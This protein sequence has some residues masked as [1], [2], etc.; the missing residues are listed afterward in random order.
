VDAEFLAAAGTPALIDLPASKPAPVVTPRLSIP[1]LNID[2]RLGRILLSIVLAILLW[3]Y[4]ARSENPPAFTQFTDMAIEVRGLTSSLKVTNPVP[5]VVAR[6]RA[7]QDLLGTLTKPSIEPYL[8]LAG[9]QEGV[10][11]VPV[12]AEISSRR[13]SE[14]SVDFT[15]RTVQVQLEV[16]IS[17]TLPVEV[18]TVGTPAIG[19]GLQPAQV[20]PAEVT[21]QGSTDAVG[22]VQAV[23][24]Q[25]NVDGRAGTQQGSMTPMAVDGEGREVTGVTF[26]PEAVDVVVPIKLLLN[27]RT[28]PVSVPLEGQPAPGYRVAS[29]TME[30][31]NVTVCCSPNDLEDLEFLNTEPVPITGTTSTIVTSTRL[32]L[33]SNIELYPGQPNEIKV[34]VKVE[35]L[36]TTWQ[37]AV[38]P[39]VEGVADNLSAVVSPNQL[40]LTLAGTFAQLQSLSPSDIRAIVNVQ[41]RAAGTYSLRPQIV[42]PQGIK[43]DRL[44]PDEVT[45]TL[46]APTPVPTPTATPLPPSSTPTPQPPTPAVSTPEAT[47]APGE[48]TPAPVTSPSDGEGSTP[49]PSPQLQPTPSP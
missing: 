43:L 24:V 30:P 39:T 20:S 23:I 45:V 15:P 9:L 14:V 25:V 46:I 48:G 34:T 16:Q 28:V 44:A 32:V 8:D 5:T 17:K 41:G 11:E 7:P 22:R 33:P 2:D 4:V 27:Y 21:L 29:I 37:L 47:T 26:A 12:R 13:A 38:A 42:L 36:T 10:H 18:R 19:Y 1:E 40:Q 31:N 49:Q 35:V 3:F 6:V